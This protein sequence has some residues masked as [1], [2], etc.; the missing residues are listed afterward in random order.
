[1][2]E[3]EASKLHEN[4]FQIQYLKRNR[5]C[6]TVAMETEKLWSTIKVLWRSI[7]NAI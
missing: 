2:W 1:M 6:W 7:A 4:K 3:V 5:Y